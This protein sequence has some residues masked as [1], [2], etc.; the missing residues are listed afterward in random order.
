MAEVAKLGERRLERVV[1]TRSSSV[2]V[3][4]LVRLR[5]IGSLIRLRQVE[6]GGDRWR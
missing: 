4:E 5:G 6:I 3:K 1:R 2:N